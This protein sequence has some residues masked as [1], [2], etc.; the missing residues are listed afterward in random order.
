MT[1]R[2]KVL[3]A[4]VA[5]GAALALR[6]L[7]IGG[8]ATVTKASVQGAT[9][10]VTA[11]STAGAHFGIYLSIHR[12]GQI[13]I[14]C[15]QAEM[16]QGVHDSLPKILAD[17]LG[18]DWSQVNIELAGGDDGFI[19]PIS[20]RH[21]TANSESVVIYFD[22]LRRTGAAAREML[23]E[24][25]AK[26]WRVAP[27]ACVARESEILH[28]ASGRRYGFGELAA[29]AALL[30]LPQAPKLKSSDEFT[31]IGRRVPRKDALAKVTGRARFGIDVTEPRMLYAVLCR[32]P[33]VTSRVLSFDRDVVL[34]LPGVVDAF[35]IDDGVAIIART[36]WHAM[37]AAAELVARTAVDF[38][39]T[40]AREIS[41]EAMQGRLQQALERDELAQTAR[42]R[43]SSRPYNA[44]ATEAALAGAAHLA[45][46]NYEVPFLAHAA[47]EP[48]TA[49]ARVT[50]DTA[51]LWVPTQQPDRARDMMA[52][53]TGLPRE[54]CTLESTFLGGSFGRKWETDFVK[55]TMQIALELANRQPG[56]AVKL[57]WSREQDFL[58]DRFRPAHQARTRVG[59]SHDGRLLAMHTRI[60]GIS[61]FSYQGRRLPPG[62][63]DPF[64]TS[65]LINDDYDIANRYVDYVETPEPIP[66]GT[67][68]SV[69][70]SQNGFFSESAIDE[71]AA[72]AERDPLELRLELTANDPRAQAVLQRIAAKVEWDNAL[73][74]GRGRGISLL[75]GYGSY[76]AIV[77]EV[78]VRERQLKIDRIVA[79]FDCG[80]IIDPSHVEAQISGGIVWGLSAALSG[81][82]TFAKGM[83]QQRNY[84]SAPVLRMAETP[85]IIVELLESAA[86]PG[87]AGEASVGGVAPALAS[88]I[89]AAGGE[90][91][92]RLPLSSLG[93]LIT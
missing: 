83:A 69:A 36:T 14:R 82:I 72:L 64:V 86:S 77:I 44:A 45:T 26:R 92:R 89:A 61:I 1:T 34:T 88:A 42:A 50:R 35:T 22:L 62:M 48:L 32:S 60:S 10:S 56:A 39:T 31:L 40:G 33:A 2:R 68:R 13:I 28:L 49:T 21:R 4:G 87:G 15:P 67:W 17:E 80:L 29:E 19:N 79:V 25:A 93:W 30:P 20:K 74:A 59:L 46:F 43:G 3:Q 7:L 12:D 6:G 11:K 75:S 53:V 8:T 58:H 47:L 52:A 41:S 54:R 70:H 24:A 84:D 55:Q 71:A 66:V 23:C 91:P 81:E 38:D 51:E 9:P 37:Q 57:T 5:S 85:P 76:C 18:A 78:T 63:T 16:G 65:A 73:P 90:R 27:E